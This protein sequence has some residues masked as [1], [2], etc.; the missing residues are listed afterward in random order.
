LNSKLKSG[1]ARMSKNYLSLNEY[2]SFEQYTAD[3][4]AAGVTD[5]IDITRYIT[6]Q[7]LWRLAKGK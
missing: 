3:L 4:R 6:G 1:N 7:T 2:P 5:Q